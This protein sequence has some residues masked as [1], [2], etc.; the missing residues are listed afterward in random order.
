MYTVQGAE[1]AHSFQATNTFTSAYFWDSSYLY[2]AYWEIWA[3]TG[4]EWPVSVRMK[5]LE[6]I[7]RALFLSASD[8]FHVPSSSPLPSLCS[9]LFGVISPEK[10]YH[11][12][13]YPHPE[14]RMEI[15]EDYR[16]QTETVH[17]ACACSMTVFWKCGNQPPKWPQWFLPPKS[18][19]FVQSLPLSVHSLEQ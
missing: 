18:H 5:P 10:C 11:H 12:L 19:A 9:P 2:L 6:A 8:F 16:W 15:R 3:A 17:K 4:T 7:I 13:R 14:N 1:K